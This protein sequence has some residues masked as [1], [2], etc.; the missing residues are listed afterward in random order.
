MKRSDFLVVTSKTKT[1]ITYK[2][3]V[4]IE[5]DYNENAAP[6]LMLSNFIKQQRRANQ[7]ITDIINGESTYLIAQALIHAIANQN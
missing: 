1:V 6:S 2:Q 4:R 5:L 3:A 7:V